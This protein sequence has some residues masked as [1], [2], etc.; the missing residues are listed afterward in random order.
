MQVGN[1]AIGK[2]QQKYFFCVFNIVGY[3]AYTLTWEKSSD[4]LL[5]CIKRTYLNKD[6]VLQTFHE[7]ILIDIAN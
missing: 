4:S 6:P 5:K 2:Y 7:A 1:K 3:N